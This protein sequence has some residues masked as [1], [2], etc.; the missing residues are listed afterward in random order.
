MPQTAAQSVSQQSVGHMA[1]GH[2]A[3]R[4]TRSVPGPAESFD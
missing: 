2:M 4:D 1:I 3:I